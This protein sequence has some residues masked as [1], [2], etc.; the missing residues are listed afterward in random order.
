MEVHRRSYH[1][2]SPLNTSA[3]THVWP[4]NKGILLYNQNTK[5]QNNQNISCSYNTLT[6]SIVNNKISMYNNFIEPNSEFPKCL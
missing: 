2:I 3:C 6:P 1:T 5:H 4:R